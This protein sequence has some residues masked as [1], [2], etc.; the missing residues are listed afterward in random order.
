[1]DGGGADR[2][3]SEMDSGGEE[4]DKL[5][6]VFE[7]L[8]LKVDSDRTKRYRQKIEDRLS[9]VQTFIKNHVSA[10]PKRDGLMDRYNA[11]A[12]RYYSI[13]KDTKISLATRRTFETD[14]QKLLEDAEG[15]VGTATPGPS[16]RTAPTMSAGNRPLTL[17]PGI[18]F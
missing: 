9:N 15:V 8:N 6:E 11:I 7:G 17:W 12:L 10:G 2:G 18:R 13:Q 14:I 16:A 4:E 1:M 3:G 5:S